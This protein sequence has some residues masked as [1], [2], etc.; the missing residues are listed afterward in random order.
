MVL[1]LSGEFVER[2]IT[3]AMLFGFGMRVDIDPYEVRRDAV[4]DCRPLRQPGAIRI[5]TG[6]REFRGIPFAAPPVG[7]LR[8]AAPQPVPHWAGV[9]R[10]AQVRSSLHTAGVFG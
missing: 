10:A 1:R 9:R 4:V 7:E 5:A 3:F 8:F 2:Q 6:V